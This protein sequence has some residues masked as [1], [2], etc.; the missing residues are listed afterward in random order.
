[1]KEKYIALLRGINVSGQKIILMKELKE[2]FEKAKFL[3]VITY[4]QSGNIVFDFQPTDSKKLESKIGKLIKKR[5]GFDVP[6][7]VLTARELKKISKSNNYIIKDKEDISKLHLTLLSENPAKEEID[8][9]MK[10]ESGSDK[11][12]IKG[13]EIYLFCPD[14]YGKTKLTN[15]FLEKKLLVKATTRNWKTVIKLIELSS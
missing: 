14:G 11:Y 7:M 3:N 8:Y 4:I 2:Q 5:Y 9:L 12:Y 6:V 15:N 1:M 10:F 13:K